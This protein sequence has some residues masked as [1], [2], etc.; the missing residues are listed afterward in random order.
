MVNKKNMKNK[1][2]YDGKKTIWVY[3]ASADFLEKMI[4]KNDKVN[5]KADAVK[6]LVKQSKK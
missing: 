2:F 1:G 5:S 3:Q 4:K 6:E